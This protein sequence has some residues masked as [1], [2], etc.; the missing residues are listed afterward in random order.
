[1]PDPWPLLS[2]LF[3]CLAGTF[4]IQNHHENSCTYCH[5]KRQQV[6]PIED[7]SV[8]GGICT[9]EEKC[10]KNAW[11]KYSHCQPVCFFDES[12]LVRGMLLFS[13]H[14]DILSRCYI[15]LVY[16]NVE[17]LSLSNYPQLAGAVNGAEQVTRTVPVASLGVLSLPTVRFLPSRI[18]LFVSGF[19]ML[20][21]EHGQNDDCQ[22]DCDTK[23]SSPQPRKNGIVGILAQGIQSKTCDNA[24]HDPKSDYQPLF[25]HPP[26]WFVFHLPVL[27]SPGVGPVYNKSEVSLWMI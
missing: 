10:E 13:T 22:N 4:E 19:L 27:S 2:S 26:R 23:S 6:R 1:L 12:I 9:L 3:S 11:Q 7:I 21:H 16:N 25:P 17:P 18:R 8:A 20:S 15:A 5:K 24:R 14:V